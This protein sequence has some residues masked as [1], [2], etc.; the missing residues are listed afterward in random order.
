MSA[1]RAIL[2]LVQ[3]FVYHIAYNPP[4]PS[5]SKGRY[6]TEELYILQIAP[7]IFKVCPFIADD[8]VSSLMPS[9][10]YSNPFLVLDVL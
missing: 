3:T 1:T 10:G 8:A 9:T 5:P 2:V 4:N 6:H 7:I